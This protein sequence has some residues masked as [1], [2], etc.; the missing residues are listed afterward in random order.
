MRAQ[1]AAYIQAVLKSH[2]E[3]N[4]IE[5][6]PPL[7]PYPAAP[8]R[9]LLPRFG[10]KKITD[11]VCRRTGYTAA[12]LRGPSQDPNLV[13]ARWECFALATKKGYSLAEIGR[14]Y[15]RDH[16]TVKYGLVKMGVRQYRKAQP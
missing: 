11:F 9:P 2:P 10:I 6:E 13:R 16:S 3:L 14:E 15:S 7:D 4:P 1:S 8:I 12:E 5:V